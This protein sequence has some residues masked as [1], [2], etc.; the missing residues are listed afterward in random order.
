[1]KDGFRGKKNI[2]G[3]SCTTVDGLQVVGSTG[4]KQLSV[5][6]NTPQPWSV[7]AYVFALKDGEKIIIENKRS[8]KNVRLNDMTNKVKKLVQEIM[9]DDVTDCERSGATYISSGYIV[10]PS[11]FGVSK[12][13]VTL[14][15]RMMEK[16][17][18]YKPEACRIA[19]GV[20]KDNLLNDIYM[21]D[22]YSEA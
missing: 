1:M 21:D 8:F 11:M 10:E 2:C 9:L 22:D 17:G 14:C 3:Y 7:I 5:I 19:R 20:Y 4:N 16:N 12:H 13:N 18:C 15:L 6:M